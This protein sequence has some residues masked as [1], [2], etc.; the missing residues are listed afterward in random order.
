MYDINQKKL[1]PLV[2]IQTNNVKTIL[3]KENKEP[4]HLSR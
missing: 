1:L 3:Q 4:F 2:K